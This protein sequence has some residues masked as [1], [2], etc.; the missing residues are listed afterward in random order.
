MYKDVGIGLCIF[1]LHSFPTLFA[2]FLVCHP[3][4]YVYRFTFLFS[5]SHDL[6]INECLCG[7]YKLQMKGVL[8]SCSYRYQTI[9]ARSMVHGG[10][11][12]G[13]A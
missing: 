3:Y 9:F 2:Y 11:Q 4:I 13:A 10:L 12:D 1:Y 6:Q 8:C 7:A 5:L